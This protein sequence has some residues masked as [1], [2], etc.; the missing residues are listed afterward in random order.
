MTYGLRGE[1]IMRKAIEA[2]AVILWVIIEL[3]LFVSGQWGW[4]ILN[5]IFPPAILVTSFFASIILGV[6]G[7]I[8]T[9]LELTI[10][11]KEKSN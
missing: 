9:I 5:I 6:L 10:V 4:A 11:G 3:A 7:I 1:N 2:S 8:I